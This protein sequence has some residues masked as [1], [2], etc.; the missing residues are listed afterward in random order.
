[1]SAKAAATDGSTAA[2]DGAAVDDDDAD[3]FGDDAV[4]DVPPAPT[5]PVKAILSPQ[6]PSAFLDSSDTCWICGQWRPVGR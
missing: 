5:S 2:A 6:K 4:D 1:M 3:V